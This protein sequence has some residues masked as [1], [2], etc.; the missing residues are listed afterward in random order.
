MILDRQTDTRSQTV[1]FANKH[2]KTDDESKDRGASEVIGITNYGW[3][4]QNEFGRPLIVV[5]SRR[6]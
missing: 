4:K 6:P 2:E 3:N 1:V 5:E